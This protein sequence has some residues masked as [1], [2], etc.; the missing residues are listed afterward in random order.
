MQVNAKSLA[1]DVRGTGAPI[2]FLHGLGSTNSVWEPQA[3]AL[4]ERFQIIRYDLEGAGRSPLTGTPSIESWVDDL[5][6]LMDSLK[7]A[8]ARQQLA[9][10]FRAIAQI[11][12]HHQRRSD[13]VIGIQ[14]FFDR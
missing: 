14:K 9:V 10:V 5:S 1:V 6:A 7:I 2:F 13:T 11:K 8:K 12:D 3:R 4:S